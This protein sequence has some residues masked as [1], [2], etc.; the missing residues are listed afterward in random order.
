MVY[1]KLADKGWKNLSLGHSFFSIL[2]NSRN[3]FV[4]AISGEVVFVQC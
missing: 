4:K 2:K 3:N 1:Y